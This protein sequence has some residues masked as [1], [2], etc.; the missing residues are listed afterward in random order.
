MKRFRCDRALRGGSMNVFELQSLS[1][2]GLSLAERPAPVP[3]PREALVRVRAASLNYRDLAIARGDYLPGLPLPFVLGS[4]AAGEVIAVGAEVTRVAPGDRV[5]ASY[6]LDWIDGVPTEATI[7]RRLGGPAPGVLAELCALPEHALVRIPDAL[8]D[9]EAATLPIAGVTAWRGLLTT[10]R[11]G[12]GD[13]VVVQ[14]LGGVSVFALQLAA[15]AGARV[16]A[17]GRGPERLARAKSLGAWATVDTTAEPAWDERVR[18]LTEGRGADVVVDVAGGDE[19]ARSAAAVRL[20]G[21]VLVVGFAAGMTSTL[22]L[23]PLLRRMVR[24][25]AVSTGSRADLEALVAGLISL[26]VRPIVD[27]VFPFTE[28]KAAFARLDRGGHIGKI[29]VRIS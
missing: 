19:L 26:G 2:D 16:I 29:V 28:T 22:D 25:E 11:I 10:A 13:V 1:L 9:E 8:S 18:A 27:H 12:P 15:A 6:V 20:G 4:D 21:L 23:R 5:V 7:A 14:G 24:L 17:V 3:G